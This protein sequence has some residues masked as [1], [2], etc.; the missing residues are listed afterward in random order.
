MNIIL[1]TKV[2][3]VVCTCDR[4]DCLHL[5]FQNFLLSIVKK[6]LLNTKLQHSASFELNKSFKISFYVSWHP[7]F[8][9]PKL[10]HKI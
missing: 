6:I 9:S 2:L 10:I 4:I 3:Y 1:H 5:C 7:K 8:D